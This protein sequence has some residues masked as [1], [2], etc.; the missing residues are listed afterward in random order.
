MLAQSMFSHGTKDSELHGLDGN[1][2]QDKMMLEKQ[3]NWNNL[4]TRYKRG[5]YVKRVVTSKPFSAD[6]IESLPKNHNARKNPGLV[7]ERSVIKE[8]EYPIF[9]KITNQV[10]VIFNDAE[11]ILKTTELIS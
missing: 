11:P 8:I 3:V 10:D 2:M 7:I 4:A 9:S 5:T 1:Q 6:E